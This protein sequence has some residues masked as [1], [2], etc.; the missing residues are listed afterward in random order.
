[1]TVDSV[2]GKKFEYQRAGGL[3]Y[4]GKSHELMMV[5]MMCVVLWA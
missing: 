3:W 4:F 5:R 2:T 1:M